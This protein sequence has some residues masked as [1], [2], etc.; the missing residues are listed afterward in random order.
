MELFFK[1]IK[2]HLH[3]KSFYGRRDNAV[4]YQLWISVCVYLLSRSLKKRLALPQSLNELLH[5]LSVTL[6]EKM[7]IFQCF[8]EKILKTNNHKAGQG[9]N[10]KAAWRMTWTVDYTDD[11]LLDLQKIYEYISKTLLE[12]V[13]AVGSIQSTPAC[14]PS[15]RNGMNRHVFSTLR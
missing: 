6:F 14:A 13:T 1:W 12:P 5:I 10:A 2:Q 7:P 15:L 9:K 8:S 3:V 11:A 4:W